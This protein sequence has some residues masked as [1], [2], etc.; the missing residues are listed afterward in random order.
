MKT[1]ASILYIYFSIVL[2]Y[3][4]VRSAYLNIPGCDPARAVQ[5]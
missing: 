4:E 3:L 2:L 5:K 1:S